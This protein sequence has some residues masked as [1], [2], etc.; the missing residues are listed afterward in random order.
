MTMAERAT[1]QPGPPGVIRGDQPWSLAKGVQRT[2]L[3]CLALVLALAS[4]CGRTQSDRSPTG[5]YPDSVLG[6]AHMM[7]DYSPR[8]V[9]LV[10]V[11]DDYPNPR[12]MVQGAVVLV[13]NQLGNGLPTADYQGRPVLVRY[14][15]HRAALRAAQHLTAGTF[16]IRWTDVLV[17]PARFPAPASRTY[18][19]A[20][21]AALL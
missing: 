11:S 12:R 4:A 2:G 21:T 14:K 3:A 16:G 1:S 18:I 15:T 19:R 5:D 17:L 20:A 7:Q 10:D 13:D 8:I 6:H 9:D